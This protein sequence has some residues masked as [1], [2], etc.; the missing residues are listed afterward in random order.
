MGEIHRFAHAL[1]RRA[2]E[3]TLRRLL[4][5]A[6]RMPGYAECAGRRLL[7]LSSNDYLGLSGHPAVVAAAQA[8]LDCYGVGAGAS[9]LLSGD[10]ALHHELEAAVASFKSTEA[11][12][13]FPTGY[14]ANVGLLPALVDRHDVIFADTLVHASLL[15]G[16]L[17]SRAKLIRF[18]HN[19]IDHLEALL[20]AHR[21]HFP[22]ALLVTESV[23]SMD[24]DRAPLP[25]LVTLK[26]RYGCELLVDEAH[27]TGVFGP[28]GRGAVEAAGV[29][30]EV[31]YLMGTFS[32]ALGGFGAFLASSRLT[33]DYLVNTARSF[34]YTTAL[35]PALVAANLA[36]LHLCLTAELGQ[37]ALLRRAALLRAG[38]EAR[39]WTTMGESQIVPVVVGG[40]ER[41]LDLAQ[42]LLRHGIRGMA[43]R[44]PTVPAGA[45]RLR[46]SL[47]AMHMDADIQAVLEALDAM[48]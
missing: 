15:D 46:F 33:V 44:P 11:A 14:Q 10:L 25:A 19:D 3:H 37:A 34:I 2:A 47:C 27:A 43:V 8:A 20:I 41:A 28:Q 29:T 40:S 21:P 45:A 31:D 12:L 35:P 18:R 24:G 5:V 16:A 7:D 26:A 13:L 32:K 39:G 1:E 6:N 36:A 9:R 48:R 4:P 30:G 22:N 17:L 42:G 38:L 23:F